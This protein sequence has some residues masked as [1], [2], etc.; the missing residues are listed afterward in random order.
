MGLSPES[1]LVLQGFMIALSTIAITLRFWLRA[2]ASH[3]KSSLMSRFWWDD[4]LALADLV[5]LQDVYKKSSYL[6]TDAS[7][8]IR[9]CD[10][11]DEHYETLSPHDQAMAWKIL[12][13][14]YFPYDM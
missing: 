7:I 6:H 5:C 14:E 2:L 13:A 10:L 8:A 4:W 9:H 1:I 12:Y 11:F 3:Q